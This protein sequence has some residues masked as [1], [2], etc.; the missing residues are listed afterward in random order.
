MSK[1]GRL[2]WMIALSLLFSFTLAPSVGAHVKWFAG[3]SYGDPSPTPLNCTRQYTVRGL[4]RESHFST[5]QRRATRSW[6]VGPA[7]RRPVTTG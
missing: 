6:T 7:R 5:A 4:C 2:A 1:P 3:Y